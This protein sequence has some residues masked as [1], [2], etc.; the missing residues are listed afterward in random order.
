MYKSTLECKA[1]LEEY[2]N[3]DGIEVNEYCTACFESLEND[4]DELC[5]DIAMAASLVGVK[6]WAQGTLRN[7]VDCKEKLFEYTESSAAQYE[8]DSPFVAKA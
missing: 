4:Q 6:S 3:D 5:S 8:C 7:E 1:G 2:I